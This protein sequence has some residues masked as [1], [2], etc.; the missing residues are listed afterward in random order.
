MM[1]FCG[2]EIVLPSVKDLNLKFCILYRFSIDL[3]LD[4]PKI[5]IPA[6]SKKSDQDDTQLLLDLG[7]FTLYT[8]TVSTLDLPVTV[9]I[10]IEFLHS[11][12]VS[13]GFFFFT[14]PLSHGALLH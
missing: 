1:Y 6:K 7:H 12:A 11:K 3:D 14:F 4:A 2:V 9:T 5:T 10:L 13:H 8:T